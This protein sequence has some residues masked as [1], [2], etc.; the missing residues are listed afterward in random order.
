MGAKQILIVLAATLITAPWPRAA[1]A[2]AEPTTS[3]RPALPAP[4]DLDGWERT[5]E[6]LP[7][8]PRQPG[9][10][11]IRPV[12]EEP[13]L[14]ASFLH[15]A[16]VMSDWPGAAL[17]V[18]RGVQTLE[19]VASVA[20][21]P[22]L[23]LCRAGGCELRSPLLV[24][25]GAGLVIAGTRANPLQIRLHQEAG[26]FVVNAGVLHVEGAS[27]L[28]WS[29]S[30]QA[31]AETDGE[32]FRPFIAAFGA[33]ETVILRSELHY[34]GF[35]SAKAYGFTLSSHPRLFPAA[36]PSGRIFASLFNQLYYG[37]YTYEAR[38]IVLM[39][40]VF[41]DS[42][43]YGID[44]HDASSELLIARN[45]IHGTQG[46]GVVLSQSVHDSWI[47]ENISRNNAKSGLLVDAGSWQNKVVGN[48][49][50]DNSRDG[51]AIL[52]S[53][54]NVIASN[55]I[56]RNGGVGIRVRAG[57]ANVVANNTIGGSGEYGLKAYDWPDA[58]QP[59]PIRKQQHQ[60]PVTLTL[61]GN[62]FADNV[63]G[64][65]QFKTVHEVIAYADAA[66]ELRPCGE[67]A[68]ATAR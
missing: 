53:H 11:A 28:G 51:I 40:S 24:N 18:E 50:I 36:Q 46:H 54:H 35:Q 17:V 55:Q 4:P 3:G 68:P 42:H 45:E 65:C 43:R 9:A 32:R 52:E 1:N 34:L 49:L 14:R 59:L 22:D 2:A 66:G 38:S 60:K 10:V 44:P 41:S 6:G 67:R 5:L 30:D 63:K 27:I 57:A 23:L 56:E 47:V 64:A 48:R 33:S 8:P 29:S 25:A 20:R 21:R 61:F 15:A 13:A 12:Q 37:F 58:T 31:P 26:A 16:R 7:P 39:G 19:E 62:R